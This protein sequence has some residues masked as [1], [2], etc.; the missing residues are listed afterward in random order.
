MKNAKVTISRPQGFGDGVISISI[1]DVD[2]GLHLIRLEMELANFSE[3]L[4]GLGNSPATVDQIIG[5]KGFENL[6]KKAITERVKCPKA[7]GFSKEEQRK[8]VAADFMEK[9]EWAGWALFNDGTGSRQDRPLHEYII[10]RYEE[11][12]G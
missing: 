11:V 3:C 7:G 4:T 2:S 5:Q 12:G 8:I 1:V 9:Y 10:R 6:G